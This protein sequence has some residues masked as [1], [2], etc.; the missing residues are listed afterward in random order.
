MTVRKT[1]QMMA[2]A[3]VVSLLGVDVQA[4]DAEAGAKIFKSRCGACHALDKARVGP[5]L[6][7]I[8]GKQAGTADFN[9]YVGLKDVDFE[10]T[11]ELLDAYLEDP[12]A[13]IKE[14]TDNARSGMAFKLPDEQQRQDVIAYLETTSKE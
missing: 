3:A 1:W 8:V 13:F 7:G 6:G 4:A 2:V 12:T 5:P 9:R 11:P 10:W 14:N